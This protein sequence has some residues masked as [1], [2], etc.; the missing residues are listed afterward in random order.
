M[1][2]TIPKKM[3]NKAATRPCRAEKIIDY[4]KTKQI[5]K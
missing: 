4:N 5:T 1:R 3:M 2:G